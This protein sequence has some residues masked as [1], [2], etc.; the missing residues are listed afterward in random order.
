MLKHI[1]FKTQQL[2]DLYL[3]LLSKLGADESNLL[4]RR[5]FIITLMRDLEKIPYD[6][7]VYGTLVEEK[8]SL[9]TQ[10]ELKRFYKVTA[11]EFWWFL[12]GDNLRIEAMYRGELISVNP[13]V[14][15]IEVTL[16]D[17]HQQAEN[18]YLSN[19]DP[20]IIAYHKKISGQSDSASRI[21]WAKTILFIL[22]DF[23]QA[24]YTYRS[25]VDALANTIDS[26]TMKQ[27]FLMV[28][29]DFHSVW[30]VLGKKE[31]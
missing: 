10:P 31:K 8:L 11:R 21:Q 28:A 6:A 27:S 2:L 24:D 22:K 3:S 15:N 30:D 26:R 12:S 29:R 23:E 7:K 4:R 25:A 16:D 18:Y 14:I 13:F 17:L 20:C 5:T 9:F 1:N 19:I